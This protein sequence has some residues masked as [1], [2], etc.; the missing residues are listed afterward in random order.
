MVTHENDVA[1]HADRIIRMK[2]GVIVSDE[3]KPSLQTR[4]LGKADSEKIDNAMG[5][6]QE[7][8][9]RAEFVDYIRQA[10]GSLVSHKMRSLLSM[11]GILIGVSAVI[12]ML[13]I[14]E[15]AKSSIEENIKSLG[16]NILTVRPGFRR[17]AGVALEQGA[18]TRLSLD[19][20]E[21]FLDINGV[22]RVSPGVHNSAQVIYGSR[23]TNTQIMGVGVDYAQM[24]ASVP[25]VGRFFTEQENRS[26]KRV[27]VVGTTVMKNIFG[28]EYPVGKK[29]RINR[30]SFT[31]IGVL[32]AKGAAMMRD[33]D[34]RIVI[35]I[36]TAMYRLMGKNYIDEINVEASSP[37]I[38]GTLQDSLMKTLKKNHH[39]LP[40]QESLYEV[41][42]FSEMRKAM[43]KSA[44][45]MSLLL[46][47]VAAISL[48]VGGVGVMNIMLVSVKERTREIGL[49][50]AIGARRR[51]ILLQFLVESVMMTFTGGI[52]GIT[53]GVSISLIFSLVAGWAVKISPLAVAGASFFSVLIGM[54]FGIWPAQQASRLSPIEAL[55]YE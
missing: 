44:G 49:R 7:T 9:G 14:G 32:P 12:S 31:V 30:V 38:T 20:A 24:K 3:K 25:T 10:A 6:S 41:M 52:A 35:P 53:I 26:R 36:R 21:S 8:F 18:G 46:G 17:S 13:A 16:T 37:E 27:A 33:Q 28:N 29:I 48:I 2:D 40:G 51:D 23:N 15:G 1:A 42:D 19:D 34:D 11:L 55:R 39:V 5:R 54:V 22:L 4:Q 50:K 43:M 47:A 45:T